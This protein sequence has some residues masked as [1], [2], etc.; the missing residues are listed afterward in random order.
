MVAETDPESAQMDELKGL[1]A[2]LS[3]DAVEA[4]T[5]YF[6]A[7]EKA[8]AAGPAELETAYEYFYQWLFTY[9]DAEGPLAALPSST[10]SKRY[11]RRTIAGSSNAAYI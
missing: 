7:Y 9:A 4:A 3:S 11:A 8:R 1:Q 2:E 10:S 6:A 5:H